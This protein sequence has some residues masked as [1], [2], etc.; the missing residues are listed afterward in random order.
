ML[1][2]S[3]WVL[4]QSCLLIKK[5][6]TQFSNM[7]RISVN[8]SG[9][10]ISIG[11][12][13]RI[14]KQLKQYELCAKTLTLEITEAQLVNFSD[15]IISELEQLRKQ[16][17]R[18]SLDDFGTGYSAI[19]YLSSLE[20]DEIKIDR[21]FIKKIENDKK[22]LLLVK[23]MVSMAHAL[24]S[25]V[26]GEGVETTEQFDCLKNMGI[27]IIQGYLLGKPIRYQEFTANIRSGKYIMPE[28]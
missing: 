18:I 11:L 22:T 19:S 12:A 10:E 17:F 25:K 6:H 26:V 20:F 3:A 1:T 5:L 8:L 14:N 24:N 7:P 13:E 16:G 15:E 9:D 2:I 4:Q 23:A 27:D 28:L 21:S